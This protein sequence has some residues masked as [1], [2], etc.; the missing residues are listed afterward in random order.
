MGRRSAHRFPGER[1]RLNESPKKCP[2]CGCCGHLPVS[3]ARPGCD[4][5]KGNTIMN[6]THY[7]RTRRLIAALVLA[8]AASA[9]A[10]LS[11]VGGGTAHASP[12]S[13]YDDASSC[14]P[15]AEIG[16]EDLGSVYASPGSMGGYTPQAEAP[17]W[18]TPQPV[19]GASAWANLPQSNSPITAIFDG[20]G[21][22]RGW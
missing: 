11:L 6:T 4:R 5:R 20:L 10:A 17:L 18:P 12:C 13:S 22:E 16:G 15:F 1:V 14:S 3:A 19:P 7:F 21:I 9:A 2:L 8:G